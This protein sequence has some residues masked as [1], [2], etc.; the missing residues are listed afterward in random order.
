MLFSSMA[1][2]SWSW[3]RLLARFFKGPE[4]QNLSSLQGSRSL[5]EAIPELL[6]APVN[7]VSHN[8]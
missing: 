3:Q 5:L 4:M 6:L 7:P 2:S 8:S 1:L